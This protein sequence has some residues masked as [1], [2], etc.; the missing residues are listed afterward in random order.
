MKKLSLLI[1]G[2]LLLGLVGSV[3][4]WE[5][6]LWTDNGPDHLWSTYGNWNRSGPYGT[7]DYARVDCTPEHA[8]LIDATVSSHVAGLHIGYI[9]AGV[10]NMTGGYLLL[11][12]CLTIGGNGFVGTLNMDGGTMDMDSC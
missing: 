8:A 3:S 5:N 6:L 2:I 4:A 10:M 9:N 7:N 11:D 1:A 12:I